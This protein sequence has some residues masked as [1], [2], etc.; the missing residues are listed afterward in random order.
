ME[1]TTSFE[2]WYAN[3]KECHLHENCLRNNKSHVN[4]ANCIG[5]LLEADYYNKSSQDQKLQ[6]LNAQNFQAKIGK[7]MHCFHSILA[8]QCL[9]RNNEKGCPSF[10]I[11]FGHKILMQLQK[12]IKKGH[13]LPTIDAWNIQSESFMPL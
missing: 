7:K 5:I 12:L 2:T 3:C 11:I 13:P 8:F 10:S 6:T 4:K 1:Q 9:L